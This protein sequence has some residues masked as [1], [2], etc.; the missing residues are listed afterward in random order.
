ML[1]FNPFFNNIRK[2]QEMPT[3]VSPPAASPM[4]AMPPPPVISPAPYNPNPQYPEYQ[5]P[6]YMPIIPG[7]YDEDM[8]MGENYPDVSGREDPPP[9]LSDNPPVP[10]TFF[11]KELTGYPNYGMPSGNA[12]ILYTGNQGTWNFRLPSWLPSPQNLTGQLRIHAVLDDH[13]NVPV[14]RYAMRIYING[15][16]ARRGPVAL[17][18]GTPS[19]G[20]FVNWRLM[21]YPVSNLRVNNRILIINDSTAGPNDWIGLDWMELRLFYS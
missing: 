21:T 8:N 17:Q 15:A 16:L 13:A 14:N 11:L 18:H 2:Y 12:D 4:P 10:G 19:G 1:P 3:P 5:E 7:K 9:V 6:N 20:R